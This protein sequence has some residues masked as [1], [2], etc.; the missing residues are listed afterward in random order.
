MAADAN[1][2][3][4][5]PSMKQ[6]FGFTEAEQ[7][8]GSPAN[9]ISGPSRLPPMLVLSAGIKDNAPQTISRDAS[10]EYVKRLLMAGVTAYHYHYPKEDHSSMVA[11]ITGANDEPAKAVKAFLANAQMP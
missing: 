2:T 11:S 8:V 1:Y 10:K 6:M 7:R 5:I 4:Q 9:Y 3:A